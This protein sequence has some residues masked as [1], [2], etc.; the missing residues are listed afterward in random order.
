MA[1]KPQTVCKLTEGKLLSS[2]PHFVETWNW[3]VS[4][5]ENLKGD[6]DQTGSKSS[7]SEEGETTTKPNGSITVSGLDQGRPVVSATGLGRGN[8][9]SL[10]I[11]DNE[12]PPNRIEVVGDL[13]LASADDSN[14]KFNIMTIDDRTIL[15]AGVYYV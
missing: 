13:Y 12:D 5:L 11:I 14:I 4:C 9:G 8:G 3:I 7:E 10:V 15:T 1:A 2:F 6:S